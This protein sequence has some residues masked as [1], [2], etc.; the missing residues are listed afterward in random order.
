MNERKS[1]LNRKNRAFTLCLALL[2][3]L[4]MLWCGVGALGED[5]TQ[6]A[7]VPPEGGTVVEP[8]ANGD[9]PVP[10]Q[11][12]I[13]WTVN[14]GEEVIYTSTTTVQSG[15]SLSAPI[16]ECTTVSAVY[17]NIVWNGVPE[18]A[19]Q[20]QT[21]TTSNYTKSVR[22]YNVTW[23][24]GDTDIKTDTVAYGATPV[25]EGEAPTKEA[26]AQYT[27]SFTGW[28]PDPTTTPVNGDMTY[29]A[30][31]S[32]TLRSYT[33]QWLNDDGTTLVDNETY[34]Y[35]ETPAYKGT[36]PTKAETS[37][38]RY[39]FK[40]WDKEISEVTGD[41]TYTA[42][43]NET[44]IPSKHTITWKNADGTVLETD[45]D[46][47]DGTIPE[48]NGATP[49]KAE[50]AQYT[51]TFANWTPS[52][53][54]ATANAEYIATFNQT[55]RAYTVTWK[56][57]DGTVLEADASVNYGTTPEYNGTAPTKATDDA[58]FY[59]FAGWAD[60][61]A[62]TTVIAALPTVSG[63]TTY[64][65]VYTPE[66]RT[67]SGSPFTY[68]LSE[69]KKEATIVAWDGT[70]IDAAGALIVP[71]SFTYNSVPVPVVA[72][73]DNAIKDNSPES[74][75]PLVS[76][77]ISD[78][79]KRIGAASLSNL[80]ALTS[81]TL[82]DTLETLGE[83]ALVG[84][85]ALTT[86][87]LRSTQQTTLTAAT[88]VAHTITGADGQ[89]T[90]ASVTLPVAVTDI[91]VTK[92]GVQENPAALTLGDFTVQAGHAIT[93]EQGASL[94]NAGTLN[95]LGTI[96]NGG[97]FTNNTVLNSCAGTVVGEI[98][99]AATA[100]YVANGQHKYENNV[101]TLCGAE[102]PKLTVNYTGAKIKK[103]YD[104]TRNVS[105]KKADF[106]IEN[107]DALG[108][109]VSKIS[110]SYNK[111][112]AGKR[113]VN[114]TVT[115]GGDNAALYGGKATVSLSAE[116]EPKELIIT[117]TAGQKKTYGASDPKNYTGKVKGLLSG[118]SITGKLGRDAGENV[119][120]YR[121]TQGT[122][123]AGDN[124]AVEVLE[125]YFV[126]EAKSINSSDVGLV[127]I[128]NQ[129]YTGQKVE[130]EIT[131]KYGKVTLK[132]GT[133][134]K[135]EFTDN[136]QPGMATVKLTGI[137]NY[138]GSRESSFR[139]LNIASGVS[140]GSSGSGGSG[141]GYSYGGFD[142]EDESDEDYED[143]EED[144]EVGRLVV[145]GE[146]YGTILFDA[147]GKPSPFVQFEEEIE[148]LQE[149]ELTANPEEPLPWKLTIIADPMEDEE[150]GETLL[151][152]D[153]EREQYDEL[154]L[155]LDTSL[156]DTLIEKGCTEI[157]YE[158]DAAQLRVPLTSLVSEIELKDVAST[159]VVGTTEGDEGDLGD[160]VAVEE[161]VDEVEVAL[162][163][164]TLGVAAYDIC[165]LQ[166][167]VAV[168]T[169]RELDAMNPYAAVSPAYELKVRAVLEG[170]E[171]A[172]VTLTDDGETIDPSAAQRL[173]DYGWPVDLVLRMAPS[174]ELE[175]P[176]EVDGESDEAADETVDGE[177]VKM[178]YPDI[179]AL[180]VSTVEDEAVDPDVVT[181]DPAEFV[182][183]D[184][185][186]YAE[187]HA[188]GDG[189]Y[190]VV[191][192]A[193]LAAEN[194]ETEDA[195]EELEDIGGS[196]ASGL[197]SIG[198][199]FTLDENGNPVLEN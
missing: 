7:E 120:K 74:A 70:G 32:E 157:I 9:E 181:L 179:Y 92:N 26:T 21:F 6:P 69:D 53:I 168:L 152:D 3:C 20:T 135:A 133:D 180:F 80:T 60:S 97:A 33:V 50:D 46:V 161:A 10:A 194:G 39:E 103:T 165:I 51:Y 171:G 55:P 150:T 77:T 196:T 101:C 149:G 112:D 38:I 190:G 158:L 169:Q 173:P 59:T 57:E 116:I 42:T 2:L 126:I 137:G 84:N 189:L 91:V 155:R 18:T 47:V 186:F 154:H 159:E 68:K 182:D 75:T 127:T 113:T 30:Q 17:T 136:V 130:P 156:V 44:P 187:V 54:A 94:T 90:T 132:Q 12:E 102:L 108:V 66:S 36:T 111:A 163:D 79:V 78:G 141:G 119:G 178:T 8:G 185:L 188:T 107:G 76:L 151:L 170:E 145:S 124:Y 144:A 23:K 104:K 31:F 146:D 73:G 82:P 87:T 72:I 140:S 172:T 37:T 164:N 197:S 45:T 118:D 15:A 129:R 183:E 153:G 199:S 67:V 192:P 109:N 11:Y 121:I 28:S 89:P 65:A 49:T 99:N 63:D 96:T 29:S 131:L 98:T 83:N 191:R 62:P 5:G 123:S 195:G 1:N 198:G 175:E 43:Y 71:G 143:E 114:V 117:P 193:E 56:N 174:E 19:T 125:E 48:Y 86:V 115:L 122:I 100:T 147:S 34:K 167:E 177:P 105:L 52:P 16:N 27:Y 22:N 106:N 4:T 166:S 95:N 81:L 176:D 134:F 85:T 61:A 139:I 40:G 128:G 160:D 88:Q 41:T 110:A 138:T 162:V 13:T 148:L 24:N 58:N 93:V 14:D 35:G 25:Y 184:G 64:V 142:D